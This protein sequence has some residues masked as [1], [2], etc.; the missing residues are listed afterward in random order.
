LNIPNDIRHI[1]GKLCDYT[2]PNFKGTRDNL[3]LAK[4]SED[5]EFLMVPMYRKKCALFLITIQLYFAFIAMSHFFDCF[6]KFNN[7]DADDEK[8]LNRIKNKILKQIK[9]TTQYNQKIKYKDA[10]LFTP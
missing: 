5:I 2:H 4:N 1:Y 7:F 3:I 6:K 10:Y 8:K 9:S